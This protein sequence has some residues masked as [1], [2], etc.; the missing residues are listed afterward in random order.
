[1]NAHKANTFAAAWAVMEG[2]IRTDN[3]DRGFH[4]DNV[5]F[6]TLIALCHS[7]L[8]EALEADRHG[9]PPSDHIPQFSGVDEELADLVIRLLDLGARRGLNIG[10]AIA[11]KAEFNTTRPHRHGKAY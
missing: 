4:N 2:E 6:G 8:S 3:A 5:E 11:A 9:N 7:E 1:M 10:A